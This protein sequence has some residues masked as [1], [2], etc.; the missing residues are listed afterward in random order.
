MNLKRIEGV[1]ETSIVVDAET[2]K[3]YAMTEIEGLKDA[4]RVME[5]AE[6]HGKAAE[7]E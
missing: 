5:M 3:L 6:S 2:G 1:N 7:E 4:V